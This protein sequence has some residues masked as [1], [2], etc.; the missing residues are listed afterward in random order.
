MGNLDYKIFYGRSR[1][2]WLP[3]GGNF[4]LTF[5]L[6]GSIPRLVH[7]QFHQE[8]ESLLLEI[9]R[10]ITDSKVRR[11]RRR[12]FG[13]MER[14]LDVASGGPLWLRQPELSRLV[15]VAALF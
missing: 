5:R 7:E 2:H 3:A 13:I 6:A 10:E 11:R 14:Q 4:F 15:Q 12:W 1:P 9:Y 8:K